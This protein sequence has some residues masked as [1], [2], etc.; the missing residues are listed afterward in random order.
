MYEAHMRMKKGIAAG[1]EQQFM[2]LATEN[3]NSKGGN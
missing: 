1:I 2:K 3:Q